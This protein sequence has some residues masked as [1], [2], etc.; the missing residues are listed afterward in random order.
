MPYNPHRRAYRGHVLGT[1][2]ELYK[3]RHLDLACPLTLSE[4]YIFLLPWEIRIGYFHLSPQKKHTMNFLREIASQGR[5]VAVDVLHAG[6]IER[7]SP[8][9]PDVPEEL[10]SWL[11]DL[12]DRFPITF[13]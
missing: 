12:F 9:S 11:P 1:A 13:P 7:S 10:T 6:N 4:L 8:W 2:R 3:T 5:R